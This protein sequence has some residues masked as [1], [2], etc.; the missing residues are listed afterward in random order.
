MRHFIITFL[1]LVGVLSL[2]SYC[3]NGLLTA[4]KDEHR[5]MGQNVGKKV[6]LY[7]DTLMITNYSIIFA[8]Y[9]LESGATISEELFKKLTIVE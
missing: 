9:E 6:V 3:L 7:K 1:M 8:Q 4:T 2:L 5:R